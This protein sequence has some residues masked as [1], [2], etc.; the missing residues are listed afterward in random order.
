MP[1]IP[2]SP[3]HTTMKA[4]HLGEA[5]DLPISSSFSSDYGSIFPPLK[6]A[7]SQ[8]VNTVIGPNVRIIT[9]P[10]SDTRRALLLTF[11]RERTALAQVAL[12]L[13]ALGRSMDDPLVIYPVGHWSLHRQAI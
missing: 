1:I 8:L 3:S 7:S 5:L 10:Y 9:L 6:F 4:S 11:I 12:E 13:P 2:S